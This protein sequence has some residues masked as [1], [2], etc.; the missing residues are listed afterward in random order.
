MIDWYNRFLCF[1]FNLIFISVFNFTQTSCSIAAFFT[2]YVPFLLLF[3]VILFSL[4]C[5][6]L[7]FKDIVL[8]NCYFLC[9]LMLIL[10][11]SQV[12]ILCSS[13]TFEGE[14]KLFMFLHNDFFVWF[15]F[16]AKIYR[17]HGE[18]TGEHWQW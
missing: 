15:F 14:L 2:V 4:Y 8:L 9:L 17:N 10:R 18:P 11:H 3:H 7:C 5:C 16:L 12:L 13:S 1:S 6:A